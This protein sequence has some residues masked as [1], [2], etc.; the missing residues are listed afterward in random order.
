MI[1]YI[2]VEVGNLYENL[3]FTLYYFSGKSGLLRYTFVGLL[4]IC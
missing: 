1:S 2:I 3:G 4:T